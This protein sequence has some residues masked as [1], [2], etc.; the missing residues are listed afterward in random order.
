ME[1]NLE[2]PGDVGGNM[3]SQIDADIES[4]YAEIHAMELHQTLSSDGG[5]GSF[6]ADNGIPY[7]FNRHSSEV[8][9]SGNTAILSEPFIC[10]SRDKLDNSR[11]LYLFSGLLRG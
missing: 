5:F 11:S 6:E 2:L 8:I 3:G 10:R 9:P 4:V 7:E 1:D